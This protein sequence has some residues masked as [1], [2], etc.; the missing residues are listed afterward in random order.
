MN[1]SKMHHQHE[2]IDMPSDYSAH[3]NIILFQIKIINATY[4]NGNA[5]KSIL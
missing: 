2:S 5:I 1:T 3:K 4:M